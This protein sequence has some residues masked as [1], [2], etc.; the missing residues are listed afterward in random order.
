M[1]EKTED[2]TQELLGRVNNYLSFMRYKYSTQEK[3][4]RLKIIDD[5]YKVIDTNATIEKCNSTIEFAEQLS[6]KL[7]LPLKVRGVFLYEGRHLKK[8]YRGKDLKLSTQNVV[9]SS[10]P[11][12]LDHE[13]S[14]AGKVIGMVDRIEYDDSIKGIRWFGHV[15][16]QTHALN[17]L[18][19][20]I[21][22]VSA[23]IFAQPDYDSDLGLIGTSL[24]YGELS[25]VR[26]AQCKGAYVEADL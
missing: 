19:G 20:A 8:Y 11:L 7:K 23:T 24:V 15:N 5:Y 16:N 12:M 2:K 21:S 17:I 3:L 4:M 25:L 1:K 10:F 13:D 22:E 14:K 18:D 6:S 9:N 26:S